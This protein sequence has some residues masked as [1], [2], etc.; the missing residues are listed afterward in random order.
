MF[1]PAAS[2]P[3]PN[4]PRNYCVGAEVINGPLW[5]ISEELE[6]HE[7]KC[8]FAYMECPDCVQPMER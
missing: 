3:L 7:V 1:I 8:S 5:T 4:D 6:S 2:L